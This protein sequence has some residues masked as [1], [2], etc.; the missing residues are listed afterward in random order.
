MARAEETRESRKQPDKRP[1]GT[2][3][4]R[5]SLSPADGDGRLRSAVVVAVEIRD[6]AGPKRDEELHEVRVLVP[7]G[8]SDDGVDG[9]K[10]MPNGKEQTGPIQPNMK[11]VITAAGAA[12]FCFGYGVPPGSIDEAR[13]ST[14]WARPPRSE[15]RSGRCAETSATGALVTGAGGW[16]GSNWSHGK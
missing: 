2:S 11:S 13:A 16:A 4:P 1:R 7:T 6:E 3:A 8:A 5:R 10:P 14:A 15:P 9:T 12:S